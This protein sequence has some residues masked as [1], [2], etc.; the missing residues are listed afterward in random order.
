M[1][2]EEKCQEKVWKRVK[3]F[4]KAG[5]NLSSKG[6]FPLLKCRPLL[7]TEHIKK[8]GAMA[9]NYHI[10]RKVFSFL[11]QSFHIYD[12]QNQLIG[13]CRQKAFKLKEDIR[14]Y[15]DS[16]KQQEILCIK[17]RNIIDFSACYDVVDPVSG[18]FLG[19]WRRKGWSWFCAP[20]SAK[21]LRCLFN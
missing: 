16:S 12:P 6:L 7:G 17:A 9:Y 8:G 5:K 11:G 15:S 21:F 1:N 2:K 3:G 14:V 20:T 18:N 13:F 10:R 4:G 19:S